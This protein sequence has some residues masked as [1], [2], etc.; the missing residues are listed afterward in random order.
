MFDIKLKNK[1]SIKEVKKLFDNIVNLLSLNV[2]IKENYMF[3]NGWFTLFYVLA[4]SHI[5]AHYRIDE[6]YLALDVYSCRNMINYEKNILEFIK[7]LNTIDIKINYL[8]RII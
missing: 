4:E 5:S 3:D 8:N 6:N 1:I 2:L 7:W